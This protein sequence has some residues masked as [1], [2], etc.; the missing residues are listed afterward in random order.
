MPVARTRVSQTEKLS[1][2]TTPTLLAPCKALS[3]GGCGR[4]IFASAMCQLQFAKV[5]AATLSQ[6][7]NNNSADLQRDRANISGFI[8]TVASYPSR[9]RTFDEFESLAVA[10]RRAL[11]Q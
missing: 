5:S 9:R 1:G 2:F 11:H 3:V 8:G 4:E 7:E 10:M 6:Q